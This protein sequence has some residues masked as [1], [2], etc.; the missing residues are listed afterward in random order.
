MATVGS[1]FIN[2]KARTASFSKKMMGVRSTITRMAKGLGGLIMKVAKFA[3][4]LGGIALAAIIAFTKSGLASVDM[5]TKLALSMNTGTEGII[6]LQHAAKIGG[7][8]VE[9]MDKA[10]GKMFKNVG[11]ATMGLGL[12]KASLDELGLSAA[13]LSKLQ[14]DEMF[15]AISEALSKVTEATTRAFHANAL[16]GRS[17][18]ELIPIMLDG[19]EG[20]R[21]LREEADELGITFGSKQGQ[22][23]E[24]ANDAWA[25]VGSI[26]KGLTQQ[27]A[28]QFA[29][30]LIEIA[31]RIKEFV[32][33]AGGMAQVA[34]GIVRAF[35]YA[36]A[37]ALDVIKAVQIGWLGFKASV[38]QGAA[39]I[40][41][42]MAWSAQKSLEVW[43]KALGALQTAWG[44]ARM[45]ID[46][47]TTG[48]PTSESV[49]TMLGGTAQI[50]KVVKSDVAEYLKLMSS[51]LSDQATDL[52]VELLEKLS[53]GWNLGRV[54]A[55]FESLR[56]AMM[57][58]GF[59]FGADGG[60]QIEMVSPDMKGAVESLQT[61]IGGFKVEGDG[62]TRL[63][64]NTLNVDQKQL[65]TS[66]EILQAITQQGGGFLL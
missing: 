44:S 36:G 15:G 29:P 31:N 35:F 52:G 11:E 19:A 34:E 41:D 5:V 6:A 57:G 53:E 46:I 27:L 61:A 38:I 49:M 51:A 64:Q 21:K 1:L 18:I 48:A 7:V 16:F 24:K 65:Q 17:G 43:T 60:M 62:Q 54:G 37:A 33:S 59:D 50:A 14:A 56:A 28:I 63:L 4:I 2:V 32:I 58:E 22:L 9:K 47:L 8:S 30:I 40:V 55:T 12:A 66:K 26:W 39:F 3:A 23:V 42:A 10:I 25:R 13:D 20:I 45:A